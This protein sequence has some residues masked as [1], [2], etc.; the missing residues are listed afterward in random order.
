MKRDLTR[1]LRPKSIAVIGGGAWCENVIK[2]AQKF[3]FDSTIWPVHPNK[4]SIADLPAF[5]SIENLPAAPDAVFIG[6]NS[7]ATIEAVKALSTSGAGGAV[8]FASGFQEAIGEIVEGADLQ[9]QLLAAAGDMPI[10]GPNCY[11]FINALDGALLWPDQHGVTRTDS[12]VAIITQSSNI[13]INITMQRRALPLAYVVTA[14]NQA[15]IGLAGIGASLLEDPR[16]TALGLHIEGV[17]DIRA[18]EALKQQAEKLGKTVIALK[19]GTSDQARVATISHTASLAGS[20]AGARALLRRLG[21]PQVDTLPE[22]V[23]ALKLLHITGPLKTN[24]IASMS[25]SGGEASLMA[26]LAL[27]SG[28]TFPPLNDTQQENLRAALGPKVK[29]ANP[30]DYHTYIWA[31]TQAMIKAFSAMM[32]PNLGLG[33]LVSDFPR[34]DFCDASDWDCVINAITETKQRCAQ[35]M[36][37]AASL[38][39]N[40]PESVAQ[41]LK[42]AGIVPLCGLAEALTAARVGAECGR[43]NAALAPILLPRPPRNASPLTE[44]QAK[45]ALAKHGLTIPRAQTSNQNDLATVANTIGYPLVLKGQGLAHKTEAGAVALN[46][47]DASQVTIAAAAMPCDS[48]LLEQMITGA[49]CELLIG[50]VLDPAHGYV[51]TIGAGGILTE[52]LQDS[53]SLLIPAAPNQIKTA[54]N[55]LKSAKLL[56]GYRGAPAAN[57]DAIVDAVNAVQDYVI[58][59]H[60]TIAEVEVNPLLCLPERAIAADALILIGEIDD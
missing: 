60:G 25:C 9:A 6:I 39:E 53:T 42:Q 28:V 13:A 45:T 27:T 15:Q 35:P 58:Q 47:T 41:H 10:I 2:Q 43:S 18:L 49:V 37:I 48:F 8:C 7:R 40:M 26:D 24:R 14:G 59:N 34:A 1:L 56:H 17:G 46:L 31:D 51:L 36:A 5:A 30:L 33:I 3:A 11:G 16:V 38:P 4:T 44:A 19:V 23:E 22:F 52:L 29:L 50:V 54:L 12:G 55:S 21:I 57:I 20:D 32:D